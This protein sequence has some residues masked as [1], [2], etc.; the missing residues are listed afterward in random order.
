MQ[1]YIHQRTRQRQR[2]P[3]AF[4]KQAAT[5]A[6]AARYK[7]GKDDFATQRELATCAGA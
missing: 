6:S 5:L 2:L 3:A 1:E 4:G 7:A